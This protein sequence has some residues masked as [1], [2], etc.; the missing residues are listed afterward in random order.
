MR[1]LRKLHSVCVQRRTNRVQNLEER[2]A[3]LLPALVEEVE[4]LSGRVAEHLK[5]IG[6]VW[7]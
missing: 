1:G 4:A 2:Y 7:N 6:V 5:T 3:D